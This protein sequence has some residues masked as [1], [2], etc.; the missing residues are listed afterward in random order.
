MKKLREDRPCRH[1]EYVAEISQSSRDDGRA[2][3][4]LGGWPRP[5][6]RGAWGSSLFDGNGIGDRL[7]VEAAAVL[8]RAC[9][10]AI[11][12]TGGNGKLAH[13]CE[14]PACAAVMREE[15]LALGV[16]ASDITLELEAA[17]T[18]EQLQAIKQLPFP[19][20]G[21]RIVSNRYHIPRIAAFLNLDGFLD[22]WRT[23]NRIVLEAAEDVL[24]WHDPGRWR[25]LID[26]AYASTPMQERI[27]REEEG[28]RAIRAG[29]Y[30]R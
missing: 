4:V 20:A 3:F 13:I 17:N 25:A 24:L 23:A 28:V 7:R 8:Y 1:K 9:R 5:D 18:Y 19:D 16:R 30:K 22:G 29:T 10:R 14:A 2:L 26:A 21:L 12:V 6:E 27:A 11:V 15:L